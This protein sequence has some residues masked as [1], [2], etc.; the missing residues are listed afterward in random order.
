MDN[1]VSFLSRF[2]WLTLAPLVSGLGATPSAIPAAEPA[3]DVQTAIFVLPPYEV[4][5]VRP[6]IYAAIDGYEILSVIE[7]EKTRMVAERLKADRRFAPLF[8]PDGLELMPVVP[9]VL[10]FQHLSDRHVIAQFQKRVR[11]G[12]PIDFALF[13]QGDCFH[14]FVSETATDLMAKDRRSGANSP[15]AAHLLSTFSLMAPKPPPWYQ[16]GLKYL[17]RHGQVSGD[18][19]TF[20]GPQRVEAGTIPIERLLSTTAEA[21]GRIRLESEPERARLERQAALLI[22]WG[23]FSDDGIRRRAFLRFVGEASRQSISDQQLRESFGIGF[24][25]LALTLQAYRNTWWRSRREMELPEDLQPADQS[26][27]R[28][29]AASQVEVARLL[30]ESYI[31]LAG[32][33]FYIPRAPMYLVKAREI[34]ASVNPAG[35]A[36]SGIQLALG[37]L[38]V[39]EGRSDAALRT[40]E[41][42]AASDPELR[43]RAN[44]EL[45]RLRLQFAGRQAGPGRLLDAGTTRHILDPLNRVLRVDP[46]M[47]PAFQ[48]AAAVWIGSEIAPDAADLALL[49]DGARAFPRNSGLRTSIDVLH[50]AAERDRQSPGTKEYNGPKDHP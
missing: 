9:N 26:P 47:E 44:Y 33:D 30:S 27:V 10:V 1:F 14:A 11:P 12:Q 15:L 28:F 43:P 23:F 6:W 25:D 29:Q 18:T 24:D 2:I 17:L 36:T 49:T 42:L 39:A 48:L 45:A 5:D 38:Q 13:N 46:K 20:I 40:F 32:G 34:L 21:L 37:L 3:D 19:L 4:N 22:H 16:E 41:K 8:I 50:R 31:A 35:Q 7:E